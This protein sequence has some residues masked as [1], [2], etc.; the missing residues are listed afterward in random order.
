MTLMLPD[1]LT[2]LQSR[3][4]A[5]HF[6]DL[7]DLYDDPEVFRA[8]EWFDSVTYTLNGQTKTVRVARHRGTGL[9]PDDLDSLIFD[10]HQVMVSIAGEFP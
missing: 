10:L 8:D 4:D 5:I 2:A 1:R 3:F 6:F 9:T 7:N